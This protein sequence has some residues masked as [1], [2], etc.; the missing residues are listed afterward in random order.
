VVDVVVLLNLWWLVVGF[1]LGWWWLVE[2]MVG[3]CWV[4]GGF[5]F[6]LFFVLHC[7]KHRK[8]FRKETIFPEIIYI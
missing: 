6:V 2:Y 5:F 8:I 4:C 7:A 1:L 3:L